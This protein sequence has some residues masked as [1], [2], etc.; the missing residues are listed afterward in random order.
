MLFATAVKDALSRFQLHER[1]DARDQSSDFL[2]AY[3]FSLYIYS[4][5]GFALVW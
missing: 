2:F 5:Q 3:R 1:G 4:I